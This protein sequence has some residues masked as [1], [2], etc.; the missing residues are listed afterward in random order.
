[1]RPR[2]QLW[3]KILLL[4]L[5]SEWKHSWEK[6]TRSFFPGK[7]SIGSWPV[8][9][10][11]VNKCKQWL[12]SLRQG[13]NVTGRLQPALCT[14][15]TLQIPTGFVTAGARCKAWDTAKVS[16]RVP[17]QSCRRAKG[18]L[19]LVWVLPCAH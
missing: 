9:K 17:L 7:D 3:K 19:W 6:G 4:Q 11:A 16:L 5:Q 2:I 1:M 8:A 10:Q 12:L 18:K 13:S 14:G 15:T